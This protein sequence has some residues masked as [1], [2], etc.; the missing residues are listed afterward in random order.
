MP[1]YQGGKARLGRRIHDVILLVEDGILDEEDENPTYIEPFV[2]MGGVMHHFG[3][4]NDRE[5]IATDISP[6]MIAMWKAL[7]KGWKPPRSCSFKQFQ[8]M[9]KAPPSADR[10]FIGTV[11]SWGG[12]WFH[13][14]RL[15]YPPKGKD[16]MAEGYRSL[17]KIKPAMDNVKILEAGSYDKMNP[18]GATIYCDPPY[19]GNMLGNSRSRFRM[20]NH[21]IF[22]QTMREWS[23]NN[24]VIISEST[25]PSDFKKIWSAKSTVA[26]T[27]GK[28][29]KSYSDNLYVYDSLYRLLDKDIKKDI[30]EV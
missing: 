4:D 19:K 6:D 12:I 22:W 16:F 13:G 28:K 20:F 21:E 17:M 10:A 5:L 7:Q 23:K 14:Y 18:S 26:T 1:V 24:I 8:D 25:A 29:A 11:A 30:K 15:K 9:K 2:G 27:R 3:K